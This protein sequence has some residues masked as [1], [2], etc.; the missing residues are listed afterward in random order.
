MGGVLIA[1]PLTPHWQVDK[2]LA[3]DDAKSGFILVSG[4][5]DWVWNRMP[6]LIASLQDG[7]PRNVPQAEAFQKV[8]KELPDDAEDSAIM[9]RLTH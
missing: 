8:R 3:Q 7:F 1:D 6:V 2:R 9:V 4:R 5:I